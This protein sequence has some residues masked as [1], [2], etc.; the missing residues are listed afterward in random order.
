MTDIV[1]RRISRRRDLARLAS[2]RNGVFTASAARKIGLSS[3]SLAYYA[4]TGAIERL[5]HGVYGLTDFPSSPNEALIAAVAAIGPEAVISHES[6]LKLYGVSDVMPSRLH[7]T[8]PRNR[9]YVIAPADDIE[10]HTTTRAFAPGDLVQ[11]EGF[12]ATS[13]ARS[14]VDSARAS[15]APEQIIMAVR[16]SLR[17]G[18]LTKRDLARATR[19]ASYR[20][21]RLIE[22]GQSVDAGR[23]F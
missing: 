18:L 17:R 5:G 7:F 1:K 20:V 4:R 11:H 23:H 14:I 15:T 16:E 8:I 10:I 22:E 19:N 6:A 13:L 12:R 3:S 2:E 21:R 9:R